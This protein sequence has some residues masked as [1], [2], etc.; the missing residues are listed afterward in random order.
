VLIHSS[1][2]HPLGNCDSPK[3][4]TSLDYLTRLEAAS[5]RFLPPSSLFALTDSA[6]TLP[7]ELV[8]LASSFRCISTCHLR[9]RVNQPDPAFPRLPGRIL[10]SCGD[11]LSSAS[12]TFQPVFVDLLNIGDTGSF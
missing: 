1:N 8:N 9:G 3:P 6:R 2:H 7:E 4:E 12:D 5:H 11:K 10:E